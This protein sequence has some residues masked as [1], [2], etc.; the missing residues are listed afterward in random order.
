[1]VIWVTVVDQQWQDGL[2]GH[3]KFLLSLSYWA[4][5]FFRQGMYRWRPFCSHQ[6]ECVTMMGILILCST[7]R[8]CWTPVQSTPLF[9][10]ETVFSA[11]A[12]FLL[13]RIISPDIN[14]GED[15]GFAVW[16][17]P[18][19]LV[20]DGQGAQYALSELAVSSVSKTQSDS[21]A[22]SK[23]VLSTR[24]FWLFCEVLIMAFLTSPDQMSPRT[25][26]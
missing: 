1:M 16:A 6:N 15:W 17:W 9:A 2:A 23:I 5:Y 20:P 13:G 7:Q 11:I 19:H 18:F 10:V 4:L 25:H 22:W 14:S 8:Q 24:V 26:L 3:A 12:S 21:L